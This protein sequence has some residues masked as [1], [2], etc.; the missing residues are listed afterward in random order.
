MLQIGLETEM[1]SSKILALAEASPG[2]PLTLVK[3]ASYNKNSTLKI[4]YSIQCNFT[5]HEKFSKSFIE[6]DGFIPNF[7]SRRVS[8]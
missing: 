4:F 5:E 3:E 1:I 2:V 6:L 8:D 7:Y